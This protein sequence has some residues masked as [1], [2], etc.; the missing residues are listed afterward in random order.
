VTWKY[1]VIFYFDLHIFKQSLIIIKS[2]HHSHYYPTNE[3]NVK[4]V[5]LLKHIKIIM[6]AAPTCFGLQ[7]NHHQGA[8]ASTYLKLQAWFNADIDVVQ[9]L[10]VLWRHSTTCVAC[11]LYTVF[12]T[13]NNH[14]FP[15]QHSPFVDSNGSTLCLCIL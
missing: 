4:I 7:R 5:E 8:T 2:V 12:L 9:T 14:Y 11:V 10:S 15:K 3:H 6:E 1:F 13:L